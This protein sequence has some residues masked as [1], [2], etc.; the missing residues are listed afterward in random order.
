MEKPLKPMEHSPM[1]LLFPLTAMYLLTITSEGL[2]DEYTYYVHDDGEVSITSTMYGGYETINTTYRGAGF[3][4]YTVK[5]V[6]KK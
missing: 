3:T 5:M 2:D 4:V 1:A 6:F